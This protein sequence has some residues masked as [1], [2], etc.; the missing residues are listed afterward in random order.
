MNINQLSLGLIDRQKQNNMADMG[1]EIPPVQVNKMKMWLCCMLLKHLLALYMNDFYCFNQW[2]GSESVPVL[3]KQ[4][5]VDKMCQ[6]CGC[7]TWKSLPVKVG[8]LHR[9]D[10]GEAS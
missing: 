3:G 2:H 4:F 8:V 9:L 10:L 5:S 1:A 6:H 7:Q